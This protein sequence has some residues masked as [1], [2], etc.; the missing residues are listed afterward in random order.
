[1]AHFLK[2]YRLWLG[3]ICL[4]V[5]VGSTCESLQPYVI[6][7]LVDALGSARDIHSSDF[8]HQAVTIGISFGLLRLTIVTVWWFFQT[9]RAKIEPFGE[10]SVRKELME[11]LLRHSYAW[12]LGGFAGRIG[13]RV[14]TAARSF[15][16]LFLLFVDDILYAVVRGLTIWGLLLATD[17]WLGAGLLVWIAAALL[18]AVKMSA[19]VDSQAFRWITVCGL[20]TQRVVDV[21]SNIFSVRSNGDAAAAE[22]EACGDVAD[23]ARRQHVRMIV[24][25]QR[26]R[27]LRTNMNTVLYAILFTIGFWRWRVNAIGLGD[28]AMT[29]SAGIVMVDI[30]ENF[31]KNIQLFSQA[32]GN[33]REA[34]QGLL[35]ELPPPPAPR[36]S[37]EPGSG[38]VDFQSV[39]FSYR[40]GAPVLEAFSLCVAAG[41]KVA[42]VGP[43]GAGKTTL[44]VL[45]LGLWDPQQGKI[46][47]DDQDIAVI[48][49]ESLLRHIAVIPQDTSLFHRS[50]F[51]N[52]AY[53]SPHADRASVESAARAAHIH[54]FIVAQPQGYETL[55]GE[56]GLKLSGGQRQRIAVARAIHKNAPILL[57]D[58]ATSALDSESERAIQEAL[59]RLMPGKTVLAIAHRLSTIA[60][61]DRILFLE[62]GRIV[63]QG[64]HAE[65]LALK[66][67]YARLWAM[68]S[69]GYL[70]ELIVAK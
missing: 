55:V 49:R 65:L 60:H 40:Q 70:P 56:R 50:L 52:I 38:K 24:L 43:S 19:M 68:Q 47:V 6:K 58:E 17:W 64:S 39:S 53:G 29:L 27:A 32:L 63:E 8:L 23:E 61:M 9:F 69:G 30:L 51:E 14:D 4:T 5:I 28:Y 46:A 59:H 57:L 45:L 7:L 62:S 41:E 66:G 31:S 15:R 18:I 2:P 44:I 67:R 3:A 34:L 13:Q 36:L 1:M 10:M 25:W 42:F 35:G 37:F 26:A 33:L 54:D 48:D 11:H 22:Q 12:F 21:C 20:F 16:E